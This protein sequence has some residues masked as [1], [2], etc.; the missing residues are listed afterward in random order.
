MV[1]FKAFDPDP[2]ITDPDDPYFGTGQWTYDDGTSTYGQGDP[3]QARA[4]WQPPAAPD[5]RTAELDLSPP[6]SYAEELGIVDLPQ[7]QASDAPA[8]PKAPDPVAPVSNSSAPAADAGGVQIPRASRIAWVHNN[9][10]NLKFVGQDGATQGEPAEDGGHWAAFE[11]PEEGVAALNRQIELDATRG[12][13]VREFVSKYAPPGSN[14]TET[15][16]RQASDAL[17]A[18]PDAKLSAID[19]SKV[20]AFMARKESGTEL[21][22]S[23]LP[24][25]SPAA[26]QMPGVPPSTMA[27]M[28][29][30]LAEMRGTPL[31][32]EQLEERQRLI[33]QQ[34]AAA[35][36]ASQGAAAE[37]QRGRDEA[38]AMVQTQSDQFKNS[39]EAQLAQQLKTRQE[40]E[41]N[42]QQ[43]M[44]TQLDPGRVIKQMSAGDVVLGVL[45]LALGGLGQTMQQRAGNRG[46]QN[47]AVNMLEKV[48][49]G[50]IEQ[51]KEDKRSRLAH[52]TRVF[53]DAQ[54]G[55][56]ATRAEMWTAAG[57]MAEYKAQ[58]A[59][60]NADIQAQMMQESASLMA[61]GQQ[62]Q[63]ALIDRENER[64]S[65]RYAPPDP[66]KMGGIDLLAQALK[67]DGALEQSGYTRE[68]RQQMLARM[69]L[70]P[71]SGESQREQK[72]REDSE[73]VERDALTL[74]EGEGKAEAGWQ[75]VQQYGQAV[76]LK[77]DPKTGKYVADEVSDM[78]VAPGLKEV[79]PGM[80]GA[81]KPIEAARE[82]AI[83]GLARLQ[84]GA[85]I[86]KEE[87]ERFTRLLGDSEATRAQIATNLNALEALI[88]SRRKQNRVGASGAP[89]SWKGPR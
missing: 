3:E 39:Q 54:M 45:A 6:K 61:R 15:Y 24:E 9:P 50:D 58:H 53:G 41:R 4:L 48:L 19:R 2:D 71:P 52:W 47:G 10:G 67:V 1:A 68:Q 21:G 80:L 36:A 63:N 11:T 30:A 83:D 22:G 81:G 34:T 16:I 32:P 14:D 8:A 88:Q 49:D 64:L 17:G 27:G 46:A 65:V 18:D 87:E 28:R 69:G 26:P 75:T 38:L 78:L 13:S 7:N 57:K 12:K 82:A 76:G 5:Q 79:I 59:A 70:P 44:S 23:S 42:I 37:R 89:A 60:G 74:T 33:T 72:T 20:L 66:D 73:K 86:S 25:Q 62:E 29:P 77:R 40:A 85:A 31:A 43:T 51:Q 35:M 55:E 84:T 56:R